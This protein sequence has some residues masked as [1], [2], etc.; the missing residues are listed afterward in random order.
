MQTQRI[1]SERQTGPTKLASRL[2]HDAY[3]ASV[4][5]EATTLAE[6]RD[7]WNNL[8][9]EVTDHIESEWD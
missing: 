7:Y 3:M 2:R 1:V 6:E 9:H 4:V 8:P 5:E